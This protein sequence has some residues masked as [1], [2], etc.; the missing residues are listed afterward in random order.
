MPSR[1]AKL[2][3]CNATVEEFFPAGIARSLPKSSIELESLLGEVAPPSDSLLGHQFQCLLHEVQSTS[4]DAKRLVTGRSEGE[5][6]ARLRPDS[7]SV[8]ECLEHLALTTQA[9]VPAIEGIMP[10]TPL[11]TKNRPLR[12]NALATVLIRALEPPYRLRHKVLAHLAPQQ[13]DFRSAWN[14]FQESQQELAQVIR[15]AVGLA[16]DTVRIESPVC[17]RLRYNV[18]GAFGIV[19]AHQRRHLWQAEQILRDLGRH[20]A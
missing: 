8:T 16:I 18:Y 15:S 3:G 11:L 5:L 4:C 6:T 2:A 9:F 10:R 14:A 19:A 1:L 7:W 20:G 12:R 17:S 13:N